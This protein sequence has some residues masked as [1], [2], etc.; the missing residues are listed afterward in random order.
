MF[1]VVVVGAGIAG[2]TC[3]RQ[4]AHSG[5]RVALVEKSRGVGGRAATRRLPGNR[6][7]LGVPY[8]KDRGR[9]LSGFVGVLRDRQILR[10]W[11][12]R[13][14]FWDVER[15][16]LTPQPAEPLYIAPDGMSAIGKFLA[17]DLE[18]WFDR[19]ACT[20]TPCEG[21][22]TLGLD[23]PRNRADFPF[24]I[25]ARALVIAIP[26]PQ[27]IALLETQAGAFPQMLDNLKAIEYDPCFTVI[28]AYPPSQQSRFERYDGGGTGTLPLPGA[29]DFPHHRDLRW[30][31]N[32]SS[33]RA[34]PSQPV[35]VLHSSPGFA[36]KHL[37]ENDLEPIGKQLLR[38]VE[39]LFGLGL[40]TPQLM[41]V[42]RWRY[43]FA[44]SPLSQDC[45]GTSD[46]FPL[47]CCGDGFGNAPTQPVETALRSGA[48][49]ASL[50]NDRLFQ[51]S[52]APIGE[53]WQAIGISR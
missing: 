40:D 6:A 39:A 8:L 50:T 14:Y 52:L 23:A 24:E 7:D 26:A 4:L 48:S 28:A 45:L 3:A 22:W 2:L 10:G 47:V 5:Y 46:P 13:A 44:R 42:H 31:G 17:T 11:S 49:A 34:N 37:E 19:R 18:I 16:C 35:F 36:R 51:D 53:C 43:A 32:D 25:T 33:K 15:S 9:L 41:Q 12:D 38:S 1:D 30:M 27:A 20:L 29:I 21:G